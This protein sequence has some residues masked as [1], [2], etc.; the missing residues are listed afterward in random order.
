MYRAPVTG[1]ASDSSEPMAPTTHQPSPERMVD[2]GRGYQLCAQSFGEESAPAVLLI[3]GLGQ[4][5]LSWPDDLCSAIADAGYRVIRFDNRDVGR[6]THAT[7]R[8]PGPRELLRRRIGD[9]QY[10]LGSMAKDTSN[11]L[12]ALD[13]E[14]AHVVGVSMGGM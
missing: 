7:N 5:L 1:S 2:V 8:P 6:S 13:L 4:Q 11:L 10:T 14:S 12:S 3:A 9:E